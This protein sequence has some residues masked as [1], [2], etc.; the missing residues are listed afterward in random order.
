V[1]LEH[2]SEDATVPPTAARALA[3]RIPGAVLSIREGVGHFSLVPRHADE[4]LAAAV[5]P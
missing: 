2:G 1:R 5:S 4:V 3:E